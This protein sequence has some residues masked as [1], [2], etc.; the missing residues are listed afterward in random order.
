MSETDTGRSEFD[1]GRILKVLKDA[2]V[3]AGLNRVVSK[4]PEASDR[5]NDFVIVSVP[6]NMHPLT[7][8]KGFGCRTRCQIELYARDKGGQPDTPKLDS[9]ARAIAGALPVTRDGVKVSGIRTVL[10]G[11]DDYGFG[12]RVVQ[13]EIL[14]LN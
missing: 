6:Y 14:S 8:G 1:T 7:Y 5:V 9:M 3:A 4:R 13:A 12:V 11:S 2:A 10:N